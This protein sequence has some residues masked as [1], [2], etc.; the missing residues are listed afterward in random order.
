MSDL[1]EPGLAGTK[2]PRIEQRAGQKYKKFGN[3]LND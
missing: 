2:R 1:Q 3:A